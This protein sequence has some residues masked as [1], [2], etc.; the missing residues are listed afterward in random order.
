VFWAAD[1]R[2]STPGRIPFSS[3]MAA[4]ALIILVFYIKK[5]IL[6]LVAEPNIDALSNVQL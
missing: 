3:S 6:I 4:H 5:G 2:N 1:Q